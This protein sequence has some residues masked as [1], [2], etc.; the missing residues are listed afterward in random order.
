MN[1]DSP[2]GALKRIFHEPTRLA[3]LTRLLDAHSGLT[4]TEIRDRCGL[5]DGNLS[6]HLSILNEAHLISIDKRF[7]KNRPQ[8][9]IYLTDEGHEQ[10]LNYLA[11]LE[12]VLAQAAKRIENLSSVSPQNDMSAEIIPV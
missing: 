4:F 12:T 8:T 5:T 10:F 6:R 3:I 11:A 2:Y 9:R 7:V 1:P